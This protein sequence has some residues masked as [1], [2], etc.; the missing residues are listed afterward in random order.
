MNLKS[1][2]KTIAPS[3]PTM[4]L[5][6]CYRIEVLGRL[7]SSWSERLAGMEITTTGGSS[8]VP[9]TTLQGQ[10]IDQNA[11]AGVLNTL[12]DLGLPLIGAAYLPREND[13]KD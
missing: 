12:C 11:L 6:A 3:F 9:R 1:R 2:K 7:D 8:V 10:V 5:P 4:E 13:I